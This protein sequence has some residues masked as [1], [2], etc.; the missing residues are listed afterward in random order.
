M[1]RDDLWKRAALPISQS[2]YRAIDTEAARALPGVVAVYTAKDIP[3]SVKVGH[4]KQDWDALIPVGKITHYLGTPLPW[5]Q[6][7][8]WRSWKRPKSLSK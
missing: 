8:V 1:W 7:R 5:W 3:G 2:A 4:L 6:R